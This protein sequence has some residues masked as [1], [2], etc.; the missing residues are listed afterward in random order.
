MKSLKKILALAFIGLSVGPLL[1]L[2]VVGGWFG[3]KAAVE[4]A[5]RFENARAS[6]VAIAIRELLGDL[7]SEV[8]A[9]TRFQDYFGLPASG[10]RNI[11]WELMSSQPMIQEIVLIEPSGRERLRAGSVSVHA[12]ESP[13]APN[14]PG[15]GSEREDWS[16]QRV[17]TQAL[18]DGKTHLSEASID[19]DSGD[20]LMQ[21]AIPFVDR[22][23]GGVRAVMVAAVKLRYL[24]NL[25]ADYNYEPGERIYVIDR[26][27]H[28]ICHPNPSLVLS[29]G[30]AGP[31]S[32]PDVQAG[33]DGT[34]VVAAVKDVRYGDQLFR[35]VAERDAAEALGTSIRNWRLYGLIL[36]LALGAGLGLSVLARRVAIAPIE[37]LTLTAMAI[38][39]GDLER[40][41]EGGGFEELDAMA[42]SFNAMTSRLHDSLKELEVENRIRTEAEERLA[43]AMD[44]VNDGLWD[45]NLKTNEA[46]FSPRYYTMLGYEPGEMPGSYEI[47]RD[48]LHPDDREETIRNVQD[49]IESGEPFDVEFR[50]RT[51]VGGYKWIMGRGKVAAFD[52]AGKPARMI[53]THMDISERKQNEEE[54]RRW[55]YIFE[56]SGWGAAVTDVT[57]RT[58]KLLNPTYASMHGYT[59]EELLGK[60]YLLVY[61]PEAKEEVEQRAALISEKGELTFETVHMR[62]DGGVFPV[63][64]DVRTVNDEEGKPAYRVINVQDISELKRAEEDIY[65]AKEQAEEAS[66]AKSAFLAN[67]SHEIRTPLNGVIG[68][69]QLIKDTALDAEQTEWVAF[70]LS[71]AMR[72]TH[73]LN[74][75]LDISRIEAGKL[76]VVEETF[77]PHASA[78]AVVESFRG[79]AREAGIDLSLRISPSVPGTVMA[80]GGRMRQVLFNLV[81]NAV[82]FTRQGSVSLEASR[83]PVD[84]PDGRMRLLFVVSD[85]GIGIEDALLPLLF[86]PFTQAED[87]FTRTHQGAGLGLSIVKRLVGLMGGGVCIESEEGAGTTACFTVLARDAALQGAAAEQYPENGADVVSREERRSL[88]ALVVEDELVNLISARRMLE[89]LGHETL[90]AANGREALTLLETERVDCILMDV[91]MPVMDGLEAAARIRSNPPAAIPADIPIAA[92]TAYAMQGDRERFLAAGMDAYLSKPVELQDLKKVLGQ[93]M[94]RK[95]SGA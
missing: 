23:A 53:G 26:A 41:A 55:A 12:L 17:F 54:L 47:W 18:R 45:W 39:G 16:D 11:L 88:R 87:S 62:K 75:I 50:L 74:D 70:A 73:L 81:G 78:R 57:S 95:T 76:S 89:K 8:R 82:K 93:L 2:G 77:D 67:M 43:L 83:L 28:V 38:R 29:G 60:P 4:N 7:E 94:S 25:L 13:G 32:G 34:W 79:K 56:H 15:D 37:R 85:T 1:L 52:A 14:A 19:Q 80:D 20:P 59:Q 61:P 91:Q 58:L 42:D 9:A 51:K 90:G 10:Q 35:V 36:L 31:R 48:L 69:L 64:V 6:E 40:K 71:S 72:L 3:Y 5:W 44:A 65:A 21:L 22:Y 27:G 49:H 68:M 33:L 46:Y 24:Q 86:E 63:L 84:A 92:M 66:K 30:L